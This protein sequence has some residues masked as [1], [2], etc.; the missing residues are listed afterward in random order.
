MRLYLARH[1]EAKGRDEDPERGLTDAGDDG[2]E[3]VSVAVARATT[4]A[5][6]ERILHSGKKRARQTAEIL[7]RSL[8]CSDVSETDGLAPN[9]DPGAW[10]GR[11]SEG[12]DLM[13][14]GHLPFMDRLASL[15]VCEDADRGA[16][17]FV[18]AAVLCLESGEG[19][20]G[21]KVVWMVTPDLAG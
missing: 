15:L 11:L 20:F 21:W 7:A 17:R 18:E 14:V 13:L 8:G 9:D 3:K 6:P 4:G 12:G 2:V 1:G 5:R 16:F 19:S 10:L